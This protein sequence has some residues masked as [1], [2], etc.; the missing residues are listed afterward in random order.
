MPTTCGKKYFLAPEQKLYERVSWLEFKRALH[1]EILELNDDDLE[2][3]KLVLVTS[4]DDIGKH[5]E[6]V[7]MER[8]DKVVKW[9]G[10]FYHPI[11]GAEVIKQIS[12]LCKKD[13]FHGELTAPAASACIAQ[14]SSI[15]G[16]FLVRLSSSDPKR[17]PFSITMSGDL[18]TRVER[19][20]E[21]GFKIYDTYY[22]TLTALVDS[23]THV[24]K[25]ACPKHYK[26]N[27]GGLGNSQGQQ[28]QE[29]DNNNT[30]NNNNSNNNN[31][32][33]NSI[34]NNNNNNQQQQHPLGPTYYPMSHS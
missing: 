17:A 22:P 1:E 20:G 12:D 7:T 24:L 30:N 25:N 16:V 23:Y 34:N 19:E 18:H 2:C 15:D 5:M 26:P 4:I 28:K 3:L 14:H 9:F 6:F 27:Y 32:N 8:F 10:P 33:N 11:R 29:H 31:N 21:D 13:W